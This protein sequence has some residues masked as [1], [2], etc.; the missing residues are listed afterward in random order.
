MRTILAPLIAAR[1]SGIEMT[2]ADNSLRRIFPILVAYVAD[3]P[4]QCLV[5][6]CMENRCPSCIVGCDEHCEN[7]KSPLRCQVSTL[8]T[9]L[10]HKNGE[11]PYLFDDEGLRPVYYPFWADLPNSDIFASITPNILH[12][13]HKGIF[14]DYVIKWCTS[15]AS[16]GEVD[17]CFKAMTDYHG[18]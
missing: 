5:A 10:Q 2:C 6:C 8:G 18:L 14:K 11:Q 13:L 1:K 9:L 3:Y 4:E 15:L 7:F 17:A 12:Q 16:E